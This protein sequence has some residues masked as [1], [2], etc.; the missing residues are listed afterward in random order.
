[1]L[2]FFNLIFN[3]SIALKNKNPNKQTKTKKN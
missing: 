1:M 2:S 3:G